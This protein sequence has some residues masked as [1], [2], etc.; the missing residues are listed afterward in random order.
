MLTPFPVDPQLKKRIEDLIAQ[1]QVVLFMKGT[2]DAPRCGFSAA[3]VGILDELHAHY[4]TVDVL[5]DPAIREGIKE[6]SQWPTIPQLFIRGEMIGGA[7][8]TKEDR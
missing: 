2:R 8:I 4:S 1:D 6:F 5:A 3:V 7:D